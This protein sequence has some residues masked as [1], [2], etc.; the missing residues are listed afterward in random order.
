M[1]EDH[2]NYVYC[3]FDNTH[4]IEASKIK[5]HFE[6]CKASNRKEFEQCQYNEYHWVHYTEIV[7]H[8]KS[9]MTVIRL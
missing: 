2:K 6:K 9:T 4:I 3:P 8:E 5:K 1:K 7:K